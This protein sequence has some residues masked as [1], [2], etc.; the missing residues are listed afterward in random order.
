M[1]TVSRL[2]WLDCLR[3]LAGGIYVDPALHGGR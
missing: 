3:L 1:T 2:A